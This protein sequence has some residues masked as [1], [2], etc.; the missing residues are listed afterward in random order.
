ME[1]EVAVVA[2]AVEGRRER[3]RWRR[4]W[5]WRGWRWRLGWRRE[6][7]WR[8]WWRRRRRWRRRLR[9]RG[10]D[11]RRR[12]RSRRRGRRRSRRWRRCR[13]RAR[14][15]Q[16]GGID[17]DAVRRHASADDVVGACRSCVLPHREIL[18][19]AKGDRWV[20]LG[21]QLRGEGDPV[22]V[23]HG[24]VWS[25]ASARHVDEPGGDEGAFATGGDTRIAGQVWRRRSDRDAPW[26]QDGSVGRDARRV[27]AVRVPVV[28]S[29]FPRDDEVRAVECRHGERVSVRIV[30]R[31][32]DPVRIENPAVG[33][34]SRTEDAGVAVPGD[35]VLAA[36][37]GDAVSQVA[38]RARDRE[39]AWS[40]IVPSVVTR[41]PRM[42]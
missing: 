25:E 22:R 14:D 2:V 27:D 33:P 10:L 13:A 16:S 6:W 39:P 8:R 34:D 41:I 36:A 18:A 19:V 7:W 42:Q 26:I 11:R 37:V 20:A 4:R 17:D 5:R 38:E 12:R 30:R 3:G 21:V 35:E 24:A 23:E 9:R 32:R 29:V 40:K 28:A 1:V 31:D 15:Q